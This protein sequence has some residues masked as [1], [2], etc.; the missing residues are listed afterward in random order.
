MDT[1]FA[2]ADVAAALLGLTESQP[3]GRR[4][5]PQAQQQHVDAVVG[6]AGV[7]VARDADFSLPGAAPGNDA[8]FQVINDEIGDSLIR[9]NAGLCV[10]HEGFGLVLSG[11]ADLSSEADFRLTTAGPWQRGS[12]W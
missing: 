5:V 6:L 1:V 9:I 10:A 8:A 2:F 4:P 12:L 11:E 3:V 7:E